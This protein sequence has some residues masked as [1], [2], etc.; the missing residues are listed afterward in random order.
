MR[1][2]IYQTKT[3]NTNKHTK[4]TFVI[5]MNKITL[6]KYMLEQFKN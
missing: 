6:T 3:A 4:K 1:N 2:V 5:E